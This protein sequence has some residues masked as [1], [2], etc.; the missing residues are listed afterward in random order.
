MLAGY[1]GFRI[2][3]SFVLVVVLVVLFMCYAT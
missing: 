3:S 1:C 2:V